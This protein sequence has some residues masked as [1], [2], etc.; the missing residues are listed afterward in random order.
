M[1]TF[2]ELWNNQ[3]LKNLTTE[4]K[5]ILNLLKFSNRPYEK[6]GLKGNRLNDFLMEFGDEP[7]AP[8]QFDSQVKFA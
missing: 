5:E 8:V 3:N 1:K 6:N 4:E 7:I 2:K